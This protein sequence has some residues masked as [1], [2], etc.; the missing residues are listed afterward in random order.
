M[1]LSGGLSAAAAR[2]FIFYRKIV[3]QFAQDIDIFW[4]CVLYCYY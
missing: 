1:A 2:F 4:P 3:T